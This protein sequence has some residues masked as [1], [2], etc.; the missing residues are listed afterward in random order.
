MRPS[1]WHERWRDGRI[2]FHRDTPNPAL[3][4]WWSQITPHEDG[5]VLVPLCGKSR[6]MT[7][8]A[9]HGHEVVGV[10]I[11]PVAI[12]EFWIDSGG[13]PARSRLGLYQQSR[14]AGISLL[15]GSFFN[16]TPNQALP[17]GAFYDRASII[18]LPAELR[19]H[20]AA[21]LAR[22]IAPGVQGL[23]VTVNYDQTEIDGPPFA[24][25]PDAVRGLLGEDFHV[26]VLYSADAYD[27]ASHLAERGLS[28]LSEHIM[29]LTRRQT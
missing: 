3:T 10:E 15:E 7:W 16:L 1:F 23:M 2:G 13:T 29:R 9:E 12:D 24:L 28:A 11:S 5:A 17:I 21:A 27:R 26:E 19:P 8:L 25:G 20:Y 18:A 22:V 6:D 14:A 4:E